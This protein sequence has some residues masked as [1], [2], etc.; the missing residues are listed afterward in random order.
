MFN[1]KSPS[2]KKTWVDFSAKKETYFVE[3]LNF[4]DEKYLDIHRFWIFETELFW[5][6]K[7]LFKA[8]YFLYV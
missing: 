3:K 6:K 2:T 7:V 1:L 4:L 8:Y 5:G